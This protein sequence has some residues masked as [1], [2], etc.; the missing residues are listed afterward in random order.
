MSDLALFDVYRESMVCWA[1]DPAGE[2]YPYDH[3]CRTPQCDWGW[4]CNQCVTR[5]DNGPC[6]THAPLTPPP[7]LR[8]VECQ[9]EPRH[10]LFAHDR[11][12]Y[13]H[14]CPWCW[15]DRAASELAPLKAAAERREHQWC[16]LLNRLKRLAIRLRLAKWWSVGGDPWSARGDSTCWHVT[17]KWRW[18]P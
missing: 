6:P 3:D 17:I 16:W 7:G 11:D 2:D 4:C 9:T 14:G 15:C 5:V 1:S 10:W 8:L 12:D 13:G 18:A